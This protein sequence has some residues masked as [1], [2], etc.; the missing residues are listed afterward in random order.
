MLAVLAL[1]GVSA[2]R[3]SL[4]NLRIAGNS[5]L[6]LEASAA[7]Q[8]AIDARISSLATFTGTP[9]QTSGSFDATG[10]GQNYSVT[11]SAPKCVYVKAAP[12]FSYLVADQAPKD[13]TWRISAVAQA[14]DGSGVQVTLNEGIKVRL[15]T[16]ATC[17]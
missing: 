15:P 2:I 1:F 9:A 12:G 3:S 17:N 8:R 13:T 5:Q 4:V 11:V 10:A 7:A 6:Q 14:N 16:N